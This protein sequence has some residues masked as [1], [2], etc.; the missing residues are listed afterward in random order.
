MGLC[1]A[2]VRCADWMGLCWAHVWF[3]DWMGLRIARLKLRT[4]EAADKRVQG[5]QVYAQGGQGRQVYVQGGQGMHV[6]VKGGQ[7]LAGGM[8][9]SAVLHTQLGL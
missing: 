3:A 8:A 1:W 5:M 9:Q 6:Y 4:V 2:H 7:A